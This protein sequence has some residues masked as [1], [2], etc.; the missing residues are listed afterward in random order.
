[1]IVQVKKGTVGD[2]E[3]IEIVGG[4]TVRFN[5]DKTNRILFLSVSVTD[6]EAVN[7]PGIDSYEGDEI[8]GWSTHETIPD[9]VS[10]PFYPEND[11]DLYAMF[12]YSE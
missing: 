9:I 11:I 5:I 4:Y 10:F 1:M 7:D 6:G 12:N 8:I 2:V 3:P